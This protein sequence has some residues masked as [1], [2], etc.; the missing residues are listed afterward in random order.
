V[1][2][3]V[4]VSVPWNL[5]LTEQKSK[6]PFTVL[7]L[8]WQILQAQT[9]IAGVSRDAEIGE[10]DA[11]SIKSLTIPIIFRVSKYY[12]KKLNSC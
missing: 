12:K 10:L 6:S 8:E 1:S 4:T 11:Q 2:V 9:V 5:S 7:Q 3:S